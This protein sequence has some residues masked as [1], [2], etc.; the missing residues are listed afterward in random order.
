MQQAGNR[1]VVRTAVVLL[2]GAGAFWD[3]LYAPGQQLVP[4]AVLAA[5]VLLWRGTAAWSRLEAVALAC[6][7]AGVATSLLHPVA[8]GV[9]AHGPAVAAG[10]GLAAMLGRSAAADRAE[11]AWFKLLN[12][13][14][15]LLGPLMVFGGLAAMSYL[16]PHQSGRLASFLGYPI[17]LGI[18]GLLGFAGSLP[19]LARERWWAPALAFGNGMGVWLSGSRGIWAAALVLIACLAWTAPGLLRRVW[20]PAAGALAAALWAGPAV[21]ARAAAPGLIAFALGSLT[22]PAL[23]RFLGRPGSTVVRRT[24]L[25]AALALLVG[26]AGPAPGWDWFLGRATALSLAEGSAVERLTFLRDGLA[27]AGRTPLGGGWRA[28]TALH[29]QGA[30]YGYYSA[31]VHSA[32]LDL[33]IGFGWAGALG[34][35]LLLTAFW[36]GLLR[37]RGQGWS[38]DRAAALAGLGALAVHGLVDW[39]LSYALFMFPLWLGFGLRLPERRTMRLPFGAAAGLAGLSLAAVV[40]LGAG[41]GFAE[42]AAR[43]LGAGRPQLAAL[44]ASMATAVTPWDDQAHAYAGQAYSA[45]G[46]R[47]E[48]LAEFAEARRLGPDEPWYADLDARE[49]LAAG[50]LREAAT[51]WREAVRLWPWNVPTYEAAL[52]AHMDMVLR[53]ELMGDQELAAELVRGGQA[54]LAALDAQKAKEPP[55]MPRRPIQTDTPTI[56]RAREIFLTAKG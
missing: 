33:A 43:A 54:T 28:W 48:A 38:P 15:A 29:L 25:G 4:V 9:A 18:L 11:E 55:G 1:L 3:G 22:V 24:A 26:A 47:A 35:L 36:R 16:P 34:F 19:E 32:P 20:W 56:R 44:H 51:A 46:R 14:W 12:R 52:Q 39:D 6:M 10:W 7:A 50:R 40:V 31:E 2:L 21:A 8:P 41:D 49:L 17:A 37:G 45:L 30:S 53:A 13:V 23:A 5:A 42:A 27:I